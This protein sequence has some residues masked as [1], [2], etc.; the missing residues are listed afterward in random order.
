MG[1]KIFMGIKNVYCV[2]LKDIFMDDKFVYLDKCGYE[3][4]IGIIDDFYLILS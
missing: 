2:E 1:K 3:Y 4:L